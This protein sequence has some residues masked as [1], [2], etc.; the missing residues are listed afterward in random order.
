MITGIQSDSGHNVPIGTEHEPEKFNCRPM[1]EEE[2]K[3]VD[4]FSQ[5]ICI[6]LHSQAK[7]SP[8]I[9]PMGKSLERLLKP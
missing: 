3:T 5:R 1:T 6:D 9:Q 4:E 7:T 2:R 8:T